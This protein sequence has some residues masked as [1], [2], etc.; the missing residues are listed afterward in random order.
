MR[1]LNEIKKSNEIILKVDVI[2]DSTKEEEDIKLTTCYR[3]TSDKKSSNNSDENNS[4]EAIE[5]VKINSF[6]EKRAINLLE[7]NEDLREI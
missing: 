5:E 2:E 4:E 6:T 3:R 1:L 7:K